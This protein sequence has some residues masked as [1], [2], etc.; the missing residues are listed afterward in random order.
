[1]EYNIVFV[2]NHCKE[3]IEIPSHP[4]NSTEY[5]NGKCSCGGIYQKI[6]ESYD[7]EF[8]DEEKYEHRQDEEYERRH[9]Y[10]S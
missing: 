4:R 8:I 9:R 6:G 1:M 3:E 7:Q 5:S 2:C 10:D